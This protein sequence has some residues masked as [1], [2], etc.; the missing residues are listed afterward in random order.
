M[1]QKWI[2]RQ[3]SEA[4]LQD[5]CG[6]INSDWTCQHQIEDDAMNSVLND[7]QE[8]IN[9]QGSHRFKHIR[10]LWRTQCRNKPEEHTSDK[11][12]KLHLIIPNIPMIPREDRRADFPTKTAVS[13][14]PLITWKHPAPQRSWNVWWNLNQEGVKMKRLWPVPVKPK[15]LTTKPSWEGQGVAQQAQKSGQHEKHGP[16]TCRQT[17]KQMNE[18]HEMH[19]DPAKAWG[20]IS[21]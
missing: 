14:I 10:T 4:R 13:T 3:R 17:R 2:K 12:T 1:Y 6:T 19:F 5:K 21:A 7:T 20:G 9:I 11:T 15:V 18:K 16:Y 8:V